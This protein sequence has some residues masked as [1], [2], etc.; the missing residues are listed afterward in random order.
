MMSNRIVP[1]QL[2]LTMDEFDW[3]IDIAARGVNTQSSTYGDNLIRSIF[4]GLN[5]SR[6]GDPPGVVRRSENGSLA[7]REQ[8]DS[9]ELFWNVVYLQEDSRPAPA[10]VDS[11]TVMQ[12]G[13]W[14][15]RLVV[16]DD[17]SV[18]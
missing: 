14:T 11:W 2:T 15:E 13:N 17:G 4:G 3:A 12:T 1:G 9:G 8:A 6:L 10:E 16:Q 18:E 7:V 5:R